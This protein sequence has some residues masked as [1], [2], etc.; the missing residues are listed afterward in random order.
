VRRSKALI[1][2]VAAATVPDESGAAV[3]MSDLI[4]S[5]DDD[6]V[7]VD[8]DDSEVD[9]SEVDDSDAEG[10][11]QADPAAVETAQDTA[12]TADVPAADGTGATEAEAPASEG[13]AT[14][15][16]GRAAAPTA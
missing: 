13:A 3:D 5:A 2:A 14:P 15:E 4:G 12:E 1:A 9:D 8:V 16:S 6:T 7:D 11:S 10:V